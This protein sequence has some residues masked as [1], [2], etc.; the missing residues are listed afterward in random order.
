MPRMIWVKPLFGG[1]IKVQ[2]GTIQTRT[3]Y[4][5]WNGWFGKGRMRRPGLREQLGSR[6]SGLE[7][8]IDYVD[9]MI[10]AG[11]TYK[12]WNGET[13]KVI[14]EFEE[15]DFYENLE[16][17]RD[18]LNDTLNKARA[19]RPLK[20]RIELL[21]NMTEERGC[22]PHEAASARERLKVLERRLE[23]GER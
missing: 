10:D 5:Q 16:T 20:N 21:Q 4:E 23:A 11:L 15:E 3:A 2:E 13:E 12:G 17:L 14:S 19:R 8:I 9:R 1:S 18:S 6:V 7:W 22:P